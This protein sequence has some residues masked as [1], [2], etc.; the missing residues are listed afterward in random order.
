MAKLADRVKETTATTGTGSYSLGGA[1]SGFQAFS[2]AF[3]TA[4]TVYYCVEDGTD[5]EIGIGTLTTGTPWTLARTTILASSNADAAVNWGAGAKNVFCTVPAVAPGLLSREVLMAARTYYVRS[6]G[7]DSNTGLENTAGGAFLTIQKAIDTVCGLDINTQSVTIQVADGTYSADV[8][9]KPYLGTGPISLVGNTTTPTNVVVN[10]INHRYSGSLWN[11]AG[12]DTTQVYVD[13]NDCSINLNGA[14]N[15]RA[16][17]SSH[18]VAMNGAAVTISANYSVSGG[19]TAG[20][21]W[22]VMTNG[23]I[24]CNSRTITIT[25]T[26]NFA[27][28]WAWGDR[29][30]GGISAFGCTFSGSATGKRYQLDGLAACFVNGAGSTY[31]PGDTAGTATNGSVYF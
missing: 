23:S 12:F 5:W 30:M 16:S 19:S 20:G 14:M 28:A 8:E 25:G 9:L 29:V 2:D 15:Y 21:H 26:P 27:A 6:D 31:L 7:S 24:Q 3:A 22:Q 18:I 4:D 13:G 10:D 1:A 11:V 17:S